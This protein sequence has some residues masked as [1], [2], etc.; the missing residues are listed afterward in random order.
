MNI[1]RC[2]S[3]SVG[4]FFNPRQF[5]KELT[6]YFSAAYLSTFLFIACATAFS[7]QF[8]KL[9]I[10]GAVIQVLKVFIRYFFVIF[11]KKI[12]SLSDVFTCISKN[13][14]TMLYL[15]VV[16]YVWRLGFYASSS[17][18]MLLLAR[19][20]YITGSLADWATIV[21]FMF[22]LWY[23]FLSV[24]AL[25][26]FDG[27]GYAKGIVKAL[28]FYVCNLPFM[29][30]WVIAESLFV[31]KFSYYLRGLLLFQIASFYLVSYF[32]FVVLYLYYE[33]MKKYV[34]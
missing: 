22:N 25:A 34:R 16:I 21:G 17:Q 30:I 3:R 13:I 2:W 1:V 23:P 31:A 26:V 33:R 18:V 19:H 5:F 12:Q 11:G 24:Y 7:F 28:S 15:L 27:A 20:G 32:F 9:V 6:D 14:A 10:V 8:T 29:A 4:F